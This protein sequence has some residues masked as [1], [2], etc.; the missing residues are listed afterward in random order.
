MN[1]DNLIKYYNAGYEAVRKHNPNAFV[2]LSNHLG[3]S[4]QRE[5][6]QF[7]QSLNN[8]VIDVHYYSVFDHDK[9]SQKTAEENIQYIY[10]QRRSQLSKLQT[11]YGKPF[12]FVGKS[13]LKQ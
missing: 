11:S 5:L 9:F 10:E 12:I 8:V 1:L 2:I 7:A 13:M 3:I 4:D 6:F